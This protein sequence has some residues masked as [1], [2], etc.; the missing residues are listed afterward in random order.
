MAD[1]PA[2]QSSRFK[3]ERDRF[4][5]MSFCWA[6]VLVECDK[7]EKIVFAFGPTE[8]L[9]GRKPEQLVGTS[10]DTLIARED[11]TLARGLLGIPRTS[12]RIEDATVRLQGNQGITDPLLFAGY[13][14]VD[15][16]GH[17]F[18]AFR[19]SPSAS[20]RR[21]PDP[22][23]DTGTG[24]Q[25]G[26]AFAKQV[27]EAVASGE[28][29]EENLLTLISLPGFDSL[30]ERMD[31][32]TEERLLDTLGT[33]LKA[34]SVEGDMATRIGDNRFGLVH[35][36]SVDVAQVEEQISQFSKEAD[37]TGEGIEVEAATLDMVQE[38]V[39]PEDIASGLSYTLK[40]FQNSA[41][42]E[43]DLSNLESSFS[44]LIAETADRVREFR[45]LVSAAE[46]DVA[47][48]P[49]LDAITGE[50]HHY[51]ALVRFQ[52]DA[53]GT[54]PFETITFAEESGLI[55]EFDLAMASK[56]IKHM[57]NLPDR[58]H[59]AVNIS[60]YSVADDDYV[61]GLQGLLNENEWARNRV[62]FEITESA[63]MADLDAANEF[64]QALR[65][66]GYEVCLDDFGAGAA[67]FQYLS[68]L[69]VDVVKLDGSAIQ[70]AQK[71]AK[72]KA[73]LKALARFCRELG[74]QT[75][76]EMV[77]TPK[78]LEFVR[79]CGVQYV[80][81]YL[82]GQ[83]DTNIMSFSKMGKDVEQLFRK[84]GH[85]RAFA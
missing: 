82:F 9:V 60:G 22:A 74:V 55:P 5:A 76:G 67:S 1:E 75:I 30:R 73:F 57:A 47:F 37:P 83:P 61:N 8:A 54:S 64:I 26:E 84:T 56:V 65:K 77:D 81:G 78:G 3:A 59:A 66:E 42:G 36:K 2:T 46:F 41:E 33:Y 29:G 72:G 43:F 16:D 23:R 50:V 21:R 49:I 24:L 35:D 19:S 6:D 34:N 68:T 85:R 79:E 11:M 15:L 70:N 27:K 51:E 39:S 63:R 20:Q 13:R 45:R 28:A 40:R 48:H 53:S 69:D 38:D 18:I 44:D 62:I 7:T 4:V 52:K 25:D 32:G 80:Q 10:L 71:A 58:Y 31:E 14:L 12:G 17:Y